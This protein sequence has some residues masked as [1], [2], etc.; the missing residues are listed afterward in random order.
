MND[1][2]EASGEGWMMIMIT[3]ILNWYNFSIA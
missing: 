1:D 3:M 2:D